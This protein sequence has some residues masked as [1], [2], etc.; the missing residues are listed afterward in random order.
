MKIVDRYVLRSVLV[1]LFYCLLGFCLIYVVYDLFD[2]LPD[3]VEAQTPL[4]SVVIYYVFLMPSVAVIIMPVSLMLAILYSLSHLTKNN[5]LTAMRACG[6]SL[7]RIVAPILLLGFAVSVLVAI[8]HET[9]GP[10]SAYWARQFIQMQKRKGDLT[11]VLVYNLPYKNELQNRDW[12]IGEFN[13]TTFEMK[14]VTIT[15]LRADGATR[16]YRLVAESGK[17]LDG[18][19]WL[20]GVSRQF[21]DEQN[22]PKGLPETRDFLELTDYN[23]QPRD[24]LNEIKDP[25]YLSSRELLNYLRTHRRLSEA[26]VARIRTELHHRL[27]MPWTCFIVTLL[28]IPFGAQTGRRGAFVGT[29]LALSLFFS[30]YVLINVGLA[31]GKKQIV[32]PWVG[33]WLPH[34]VFLAVGLALLYRMR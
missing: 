13:T 15:Q 1:P 25:E 23:E 3:F 6:I 28:G 32:A 17:W 2:H 33:G 18:R 20:R 4:K 19:W 30:L 22:N 11:T 16:A 12:V 31:L 14:N 26:T 8:V 24:F 29:L 21:Y 27:A 5:E 10:W 9:L 7:V 34:L